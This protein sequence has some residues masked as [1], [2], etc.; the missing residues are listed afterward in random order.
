MDRTATLALARRARRFLIKVGQE[1]L[2]FDAATNPI[3]DAQVQ[4]CLIHEDGFLRVP[5]LVVG[6]LLIRGFTEE[7]YQ[8]ALEG[9]REPGS[10]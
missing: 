4:V 9:A 5:V 7:L 6:D 2:R 1:T 8:E 10:V 3:S